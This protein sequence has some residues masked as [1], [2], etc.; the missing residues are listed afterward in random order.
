MTDLDTHDRNIIMKW[1][2][3]V[4]AGSFKIE[5]RMERANVSVSIPG[6]MQ[7][8]SVAD[9]ERMIRMLDQARA[10]LAAF[11]TMAGL[12]KVT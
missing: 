8:A 7:Y 1:E 9:L 4:G 6:V 3:M 5:E 11:G 12:E 2:T 10:R